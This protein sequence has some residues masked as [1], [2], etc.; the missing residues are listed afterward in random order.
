LRPLH[1]DRKWKLAI[2]ALSYK[3]AALKALIC[4]PKGTGKSTFSRYLVN[5]LLS[6]APLV[7]D[8]HNN[9]DGVAF[10][11]L[12]PGQPEFSPIGEIYLAHLNTPC[13]GPPFS[14]PT[15]EGSQ[16]GRIIRAHHIGATSSKEDPDHYAI[17]AMNL[18]D[19]YR[20]LLSTY[21]QCPLV[22]NFPG[23]IFGLGLEIALWLIRS[24]G[25]SD[26]IYMSEKGPHEVIMPLSQ[27]AEEAF[28]ALTTLPSQP[29]EFTTRSNVQLRAMQMQSY[30]HMS[31][32]PGVHRPFWSEKPLTWCNPILVDYA[33]PRRGILGIMVQ[34][35]RLHPDVLRDILESATI[36]MVAIEDLGA[37]TGHHGS[38]Q[39]EN[40]T[41]SDEEDI[42]GMGMKVCNID[43]VSGDIGMPG[44]A[45]RLESQSPQQSL[46]SLICR[47]PHEGLPY[48]FTGAGSCVPLDPRASHSLGLAFVREIDIS[49]R[50]IELITPVPASKI[51]EALKC[52]KGI[53]LLR[54]QLDNA[55]WAISEEYYAARTAERRHLDSI[56]RMRNRKQ[57]TGEEE[58]RESDLK[59]TSRRLRNQVLRAS[60]R[61]W[62]TVAAESKPCLTVER[63]KWKL[64]KKAYTANESESD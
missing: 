63:K 25:L 61:P 26:V 18:M 33:N 13:F 60:N 62:M 49:A 39:L 59:R 14:H 2:E 23:W 1:L 48:L 51:H 8:G 30:F 3:G 17:A 22:I 21:P 52:G 9:S 46:E 36:A 27:A 15:L 55:S 42:P 6:P 41:A 11:D 12:D 5:Y 40:G 24:L 19:H 7:E 64:R 38:P 4:G 37:I 58:M 44:S 50:K 56:A 47:T 16:T 43:Q 28:I 53:V 29:V 20:A 32:P 10:L 34:G 57:R 35:G 45:S 31:Y 54:G